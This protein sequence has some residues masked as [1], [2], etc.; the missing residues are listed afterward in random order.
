MSQNDQQNSSPFTNPCKEY[1]LCGASTN[2]TH[3][4]A[5]DT[6]QVK[7]AMLRED[8]KKNGKGNDIGHFSVRPPYPKDIVT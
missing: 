1:F 4:E 8:F 2:T 6:C 3:N 5:R 7:W